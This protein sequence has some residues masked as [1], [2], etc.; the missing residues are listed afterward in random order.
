MN[1][2]TIKIALKNFF[3]RKSISFF[4]LAGLTIAFTTL[5]YIYSYISFEL[6]YDSH[7]EKSGRIYRISGE[8]ITP[9]STA[10]HAI[11][12]P[13][14]GR[15]LKEHFPAVEDFT[16]LI[17]IQSPIILESENMKIAIEEAYYAN[18]AVFRMFTLEF[19][20]GD[21]ETALTNPQ[22]IVI[23]R[24]LSS[25]VFG[26]EDPVGRTIREGDNL[27]TVV[28]VIKDAP[29]NSHHKF[30]VFLSHPNPDHYPDDEPEWSAAEW[31]WMPSAYH[32]IL[33]WPG[34]GIEDITDNFGPFYKKYMSPFGEAINADFNPIVIPLRD[35]HFSQH[36]DYDYPK[37][38]MTYH[39]FLAVV[40]LFVLLIA[41]TNY[42]NLLVSRNISHS[43]S[44]GIKKVIG[45]GNSD[46]YFQYLADSMICILFSL[47]LALLLFHISLPYMEPHTGLGV[48]NHKP[49][50]ILLFSLI[51]LSV[52]GFTTALIPFLN[53][54]GK[55]GLDLI[56]PRQYFRRKGSIKFGRLSTIFQYAL[57][58]VLLI[59][60]FFVSRQ[61]NFMV[62]SDMGF[63]K[64]NILLIR[65][66]DP[67]DKMHHI[68][69][70]RNELLRN[71]YIGAIAISTNVPGEVMGTIG[72]PIKSDGEVT[73]RIVKVMG[74]DHDYIP[75][76]GMELVS[77]RN[78]DQSFSDGGL[79]SVIVNEAFISFCGLS[80]DITGM[81][82][83]ETSVIG[84]LKNVSFNSLHNPAEP[85]AFYLTN[86]P[87]G[88]M[89][90]RLVAD[91]LPEVIDA[92]RAI[93][94]EIFSN[95]PFEYQFLD[96]KVA[97]MYAEEKRTNGLMG[98]FTLISIMLSMMGLINLSS[99][100]MQ[101]RTKEI[102]IRK[103][104]GARAWRVMAML[105]ADFIKWVAAAFVIAI[106][107]AWYA[108]NRWLQNFAFR[109]ELS[110]WIFALAG[111][112]ALVIALLTVSW[113]AWRAAR[114]NPVE[115]LR[116]E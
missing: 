38:N 94:E 59:S 50:D 110:W 35:L 67:S 61:M 54:L 47:L 21:S 108:M 14:M 40:G 57:S 80:G 6:G 97:M 53:Q 112:M 34:S 27:L 70:F 92:I 98:G 39:H 11:L 31:Y 23:N 25:R 95:S 83:N 52:I 60:A 106:P 44:T 26:N 16:R 18:P 75:L 66:A 79:N 107:V 4:S 37:G 104:N 63:D 82:I 99:I 113:Q 30:N 41:I 87:A 22:E 101:R 93:W 32:F 43:K 33:L 55:S 109:I 103:V 116:Y 73:T 58:I 56:R 7:H 13:L 10:R 114:R 46:L 105:N 96:Q 85:I 19:I 24:S 74:I 86:E 17:P 28:G 77:G 69:T 91:K 102:G 48:N 42:S 29:R 1:L 72:F 115:A 84:V 78:F 49:G 45:A 64:D 3:C 111:L 8:I 90:I 36:M 9:G 20:Y 12:G 65:M 81:Q 2:I 100:I 51:L 5:F 71:P 68:T 88:Y 15:G 89:N 76:M 62:N